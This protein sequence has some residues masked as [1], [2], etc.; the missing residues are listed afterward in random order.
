MHLWGVCKVGVYAGPDVSEN[1]LVLA[2]DAS[3]AKSYP[4]SGTTWTDLSGNGN[5]GTLVNGPT[6]SSSNGGSI[7][8]DGTNDYALITNP[9]TLKNQNFTISTWVNPGIQNS[10]LVSMIDFDHGVAQGWIL[11]SED[12]ITNRYYYFAWHDGTQFQPLGGYGAGKGI[13]L[14]T[15]VWQNIVYSKNGT[16]LIGYL[17]GSQIYTPTAG[18]NA[19]VSYG[20]NRNLTIGDWVITGRVFKGNIS[21]SL[22]YNRALTVTEIQQNYNATKSRFGL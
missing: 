5:N 4:G 16:S 11:Q 17:N 1:G 7:V 20:S 2:L 3:N 9:T 10:G 8:F 22:I 12:A 15:S 19:N 21:N 13:Q 6:Y 18:S 14:T